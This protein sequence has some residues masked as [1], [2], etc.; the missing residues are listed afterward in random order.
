MQNKKGK[1]D[2][3]VAFAI[4][5]LIIFMAFNANK[6]TSTQIAS[7]PDS[8]A[9]GNVAAENTIKIVGAPCTQAT[10]LTSSVIRRYTD[11]AQTAENVTVVQN[12]VLRGTI[13]HGGTTTVQSGPNGD[14]LDLYPAFDRSA[15]FYARHLRGTLGTCTGSATSG[16]AAFNE[17]PR[18]D[19]LGDN[20]KL[21]KPIRF[22][23]ALVYPNKVM[24]IDTT[25]NADLFS[26]VN[27]GQ[28]NQNT[29][30]QGQGTG[31][32]LT[33]GS[34]GSGSVTITFRPGYNLAIGPNGNVL[35]CQ[36]TQAV[37]Q[38]EAPLSV[39]YAGTS[40]EATDTKPSST[41]YPLVNANNTV[42][43]FAFP[44]V[45]GRA[46][47]TVT[48]QLTARADSNHNP[49]G[50]NDRINCTIFDSDFYQRQKDGKYVL[51]IENRDVNDNLGR[52]GTGGTVV[53]TPEASFEIG[54]A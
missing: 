34:G 5:G 13:A 27:D 10:T 30:G 51:D 35:A 44:G 33:I 47:P 3:L 7:N 54:V 26:I 38:T 2:S 43:A 8:A 24:Q 39:T 11:V 37:Y 15:T 18:E 49:S 14:K 23:G 20:V 42:K 28:A 9:S 46:T 17:V 52:G 29:G 45:D 25:A 41:N 40:L 12:G 48:I 6:G 53:T 4:I 1:T 50:T 32:N 19:D 36:L 16:D 22:E 21:G 31:A